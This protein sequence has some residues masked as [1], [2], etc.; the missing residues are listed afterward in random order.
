MFWTWSIFDRLL[1]TSYD[2]AEQLSEPN[3]S[4]TISKHVVKRRRRQKN[5][6][7]RKQLNRSDDD[8]RLE[9]RTPCWSRCTTRTSRTFIFSKVESNRQKRLH[10]ELSLQHLDEKNALNNCHRALNQ[11]SH[12]VIWWWRNLHWKTLIRQF[13]TKKHMLTSK[14]ARIDCAMRSSHMQHRSWLQ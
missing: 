3:Y 13:E 2:S 7:K 10:C 9:E 14:N 5:E 1:S 12:C 4:L 8:A 11:W 6:K